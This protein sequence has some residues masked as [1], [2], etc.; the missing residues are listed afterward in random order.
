MLSFTFSQSTVMV[1]VPYFSTILDTSMNY[2]I[3]LPPNY[4]ENKKYPIVYLL[5]GVDST[6]AYYVRL[7]K[8]QSTVDTLISEQ[9]IEEMV[10]VTPF[11]W[12]SWYVNNY[13]KTVL[14]ESFFINEFI[15]FIEST[16]SIDSRMERRGIA[17]L[18]MGG[19]GSLYYSFNYPLL[20]SS[21][22]PM[23]PAVHRED[24]L[25]DP[26]INSM[27]RAEYSIYQVY[28][29]SR[30]YKERNIDYMV[31]TNG[32]HSYNIP[33]RISIG[34][35]DYLV[36][37]VNRLHKQMDTKKLKHEFHVKHGEHRYNFWEED[38]PYTLQYVSQHFSNN[39]NN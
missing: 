20:F 33:I 28:N 37:E 21:C 3:Y 36:Y 16:Y 39:L 1:H 19:Y 8:L 32:S 23:S 31:R 10:I 6:D 26:D 11:A 24:L 34:L 5:H 35:E 13:D 29:N 15:P 7:T 30:Y 4:T 22:G 2:T 38:L 18:S 9:L 17:G 14:Y 25:D 27:S 12:N